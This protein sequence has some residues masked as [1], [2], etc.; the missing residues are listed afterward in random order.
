MFLAAVAIAGTLMLLGDPAADAKPPLPTPNTVGQFHLLP[1]KQRRRFAF[2]FMT[3]H[4]VD[5]CDLGRSPLSRSAARNVLGPVVRL[6]KPGYDPADGGRIRAKAP[7][8]Y[9]I[10]RILANIG[11]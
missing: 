2:H 8:G 4:P 3:T 7:V 1:W 9:G 11:C 5:P 6:V 10:R